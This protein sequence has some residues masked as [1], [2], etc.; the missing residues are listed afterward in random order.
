M[1]E[2]PGSGGPPG[3][4]VASLASCRSFAV[5]AFVGRK[6]GGWPFARFD[7]GPAGLRVR[8][9]F[10]WFAARSAAKETITSVSV[11]RTI[12]GA[13][14]LRFEDSARHLADVHVHLRLTR[15]ARVID[16][17][18]RSGYAVLDRKSGA[19]LERLPKPR[20][21]L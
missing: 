19:E 6:A 2:K 16:E 5:D 20:R 17:L 1:V 21:W 8:L 7:I 10:P 18:R 12:G 13:Y 11:G 14:C 3:P 15:Q 4:D 9:P